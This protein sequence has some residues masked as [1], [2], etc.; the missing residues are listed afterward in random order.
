MTGTESESSSI[1]RGLRR[2]DPEL[3]DRLITQYH[4]RLIR[5]L[6]H[7][8]RNR[9]LAEDLAQETWLRVL[10]RGHQFNGKSEFATWLYTVA[11]NLMLDHF[12]RKSTVSLEGLVE[13]GEHNSLEPVDD[14]PLAWEALAAHEQSE[15]ITAALAGIPGEY[16]EVVVLR[17]LEGLRLEEIATVIG[18]P[19]GTVKSRLYRG[20]NALL[21]RLK[22]TRHE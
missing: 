2:R 16:R 14:A 4:H 15:K 3:L 13:S 18:L 11:R 5:Y 10:E 8:S 1:A 7:L 9:E 21:A 19:L 6:A 17:F 12:R 20:L 22:G